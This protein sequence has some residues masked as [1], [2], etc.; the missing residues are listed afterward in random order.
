[1]SAL[2]RQTAGAAGPTKL[3]CLWLGHSLLELSLHARNIAVDVFVNLLL[4]SKTGYLCGMVLISCSDMMAVQDCAVA[5]V[6]AL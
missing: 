5:V 2:V 1:M 4:D 3:L 6:L